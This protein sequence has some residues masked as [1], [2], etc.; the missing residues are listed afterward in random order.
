[1]DQEERRIKEL[2]EKDY[3]QGFVVV[4]IDNEEPPLP[5]SAVGPFETYQKADEYG[6]RLEGKVGEYVVEALRPPE[7]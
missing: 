6:S 2:I 7:E 3:G 1:M 4:F 5:K